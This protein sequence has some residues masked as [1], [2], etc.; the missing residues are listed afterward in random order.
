MKKT[1]SLILVSALLLAAVP[2]MAQEEGAELV[3][4]SWRTEDIAQWEAIIAAFNEAYP[5]I[6]VTFEP[7]LNTE[8]DAQLLAALEAG[9]GPD[10]ITCRPFDA[11]LSL[12][13]K[14]FLSA[15]TD[16]PELDAFGDV[17][18][19]GWISDDGEAYCVPMASVMHGFFYN[20]DM[21]EENGW[22]EPETVDEFMALLEAI[23]EAG[24]TPLALGSKDGWTVHTMGFHNVGPNWWN[25]E[26]GRL[27]LI[28]GDVEL[29]DPMFVE[30]M[31][32][33][34]SW[35]PYMPE[36][37]EAIGYA[38]TQQ[39]FPFE[40]AAI[41]PTGSWEI[42]IF[43]DTAEFELGLFKPPVPEE[44]QDCY[45]CDHVDIAMGMNPDTEYPEAA[46][47]FLKWVAG[48]EFA[49][50]YTNMQPGFFSLS[51]HEIEIEDPLAQEFVSWRQE[52]E[53]TI[54]LEYQYLN[55]GEI[56][57]RTEGWALDPVMMAGDMTPYEVLETLQG[58][59]WYPEE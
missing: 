21:F 25:G 30:P 48:P 34:Y 24:I 56:S 15:I 55:R 47:I 29:T 58:Y 45:V 40:Q 59:L 54:R 57:V 16:W 14:G 5:D 39:L 27:A 18:R 50:L 12:Y 49:Q 3:I 13:E 51:D 43:Q 7:T 6:K 9:T 37:H 42:P 8:Y 33:V 31:E 1:L 38:D 2:A 20:V 28:A 35:E 4:G 17:A 41:F 52:C 23:K 32:F 26:E 53:T 46:E 36:G 19:S 11:S 44:G 22:E 10:I